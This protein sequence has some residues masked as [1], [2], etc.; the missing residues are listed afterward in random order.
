MGDGNLGFSS[1]LSFV[2]V[3]AGGGRR[4][5]DADRSKIDNFFLRAKVYCSLTFEFFSGSKFPQKKKPRLFWMGNVI[6]FGK[7]GIFGKIS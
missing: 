1:S 2:V 7:R 4:G 3:I 5:V 6:V